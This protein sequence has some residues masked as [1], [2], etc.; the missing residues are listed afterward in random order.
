[1]NPVP[2][3]PPGAYP[4]NA[5]T[6]TPPREGAA[7]RAPRRARDRR[8]PPE[9]DGG[10]PLRDI[11]PTHGDLERGPP[12]AAP[13]DNRACRAA[14]AGSD[15]RRIGR[16][17]ARARHVELYA[18]RDGAAGLRQGHSAAAR[19]AFRAVVAEPRPV[20]T[21]GFAPL[22]WLRAGEAWAGPGALALTTHRW[23]GADLRRS[24]LLLAG[25][26]GGP[27][28]AH[29]P[30]GRL[31]CVAETGLFARECRAWRERVLE[32][33]APSTDA[34]LSECRA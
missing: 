23:E 32:A 22:R 33:A 24:S 11:G 18:P 7:V 26:G 14:A 27:R 16:F 3:E 30:V 31:G 6:A 12:F 34:Y 13:A 19:R 20:P 17:D 29:D 28:R 10:R 8:S 21:P 1:M 25:D 4:R 9:L 15:P 2:P 5:S